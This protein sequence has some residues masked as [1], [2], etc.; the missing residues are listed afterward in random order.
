MTNR[1]CGLSINACLLACL[2]TSQVWHG[3]TFDTYQPKRM[4]VT[5][6]VQLFRTP[7][8]RRPPQLRE[9]S[10]CR[11]FGGVKTL[12][13]FTSTKSASGMICPSTQMAISTMELTTRYLVFSVVRIGEAPPEKKTAVK[14]KSSGIWKRTSS[15]RWER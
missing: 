10:G 4:D 3:Q 1:S 14:K 13:C 6:T 9:V 11:S 2:G 5:E 12:L 7:R 15:A 8:R